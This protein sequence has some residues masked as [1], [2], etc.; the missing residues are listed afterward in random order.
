MA[1]TCCS[2]RGPW[3]SRCRHD[4]RLW[5]LHPQYLDPAGLVALWREGLLAQAVLLGRTRGYTHHPQLIRFLE[6][7]DPVAA[8]AGYLH[9]VVREADRRGYSFDRSKLPAETATQP[10]VLTNGQLLIE[11]QH[12]QAK[13]R[14]RSPERHRE[15]AG[16]KKPRPHPSFVLV[17]GPVA[18]WGGGKMQPD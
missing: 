16:L 7:Q 8:I 15:I 18:V 17:R 1:M 10:I 14:A 13:L 11:W 9:H 4:V 5:S 3:K 2:S 12:L 6:Q